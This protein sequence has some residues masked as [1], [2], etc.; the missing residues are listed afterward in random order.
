ML[1]VQSFVGGASSE[2]RIARAMRDE[3]DARIW[4]AH[5]EAYSASVSAICS[6]LLDR[7]RGLL[8]L[9]RAEGGE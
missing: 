6:A 9:R 5:H 2:E 4:L 8:A 7:L 3:I 1:I